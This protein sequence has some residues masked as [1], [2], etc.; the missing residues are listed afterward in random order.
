VSG[1]HLKFS[2]IFKSE[3]ET[4]MLPWQL[5]VL[6]GTVHI[7]QLQTIFQRANAFPPKFIFTVIW[8]STYIKRRHVARQVSDFDLSI[9]YFYKNYTNF[10]LKRPC[11]FKL[12]ELFKKT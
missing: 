9:L 3:L 6:D 7:T 10:K 5:D 4:K 12:I 2:P 1:N 11:G 8:R